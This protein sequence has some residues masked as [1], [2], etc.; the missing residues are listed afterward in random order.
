MKMDN[1][2]RITLEVG[3]LVAGLILHVILLLNLI[4]LFVR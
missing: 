4:D 2:T 3:V 1:D